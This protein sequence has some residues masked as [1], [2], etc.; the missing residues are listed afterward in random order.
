MA[1]I[2]LSPTPPES[3][4]RL[5]AE[6]PTARGGVLEGFAVLIV[7]LRIGEAVLGIFK[8]G[9]LE[10]SAAVFVPPRP[11]AP[12]RFAEGVVGTTQASYAGPW[13]R[14]QAWGPRRRKLVVVIDNAV[15]VEE[16]E[17]FFGGAIPPAGYGTKAEAPIDH[18]AD[19]HEAA[20][21][22]TSATI[23][24]SL[25]LLSTS[26]PLPVSASASASVSASVSPST[27]AGP[28]I[29]EPFAAH[30]VT[31]E[32]MIETL[33][34]GKKGQRC[35]ADFEAFAWDAPHRESSFG[36]RGDDAGEEAD[37]ASSAAELTDILSVENIPKPPRR[38]D[39]DDNF[40]RSMDWVRA[41]G[42]NSIEEMLNKG[43]EHSR[44]GF[45]GQF[46]ATPYSREQLV[47]GINGSNLTLLKLFPFL[48]V[49][50]P[51][52]P[53]DA[54]EK[55]D[56][57]AHKNLNRWLCTR[58]P[59]DPE[60]R[61]YALARENLPAHGIYNLG[62]GSPKALFLDEECMKPFG[63]L[64]G[65]FGSRR[66]LPS[67]SPMELGCC[68]FRSFVPPAVSA[69]GRQS[70][71]T[72]PPS[73]SSSSPSSVACV[74]PRA[75]ILA[76][77]IDGT[78]IK[79]KGD[80]AHA[81]TASDFV[82]AFEGAFSKVRDFHR[83]GFKIV[84]FTNQNGIHSGMTHGG[85]VLNRLDNVLAQLGVPAQLFMAPNVGNYRKP[86]A[87]MFLLFAA[88]C[89]GGVAVDF[90][91]SLFVGDMAGRPRDRSD[92]DLNFARISG[93]RFKT[94]EEF[95]ASADASFSAALSSL[96]KVRDVNY[97]KDITSLL[98]RLLPLYRARNARP[99]NGKRGDAS[100]FQ[101][102][103]ALTK[104]VGIISRLP[105]RV[106][107]EEK[108]AALRALPWI[109][110]KTVEKIVEIVTTGSLQRLV[111]LQRDVR[112]EIQMQLIKCPHIGPSTA[113]RLRRDHH[114][115]S[116]EDVKRRQ[117]ELL[118][119][120]A[121]V[122]SA[123]KHLPYL[124]DLKKRIPRAESERVL[125]AMTE[126][127]EDKCPGVRFH[128]LMGG[129]FRR[130]SP[131]TS[132]FDCVLSPENV[133]IFAVLG[134]LYREMRHRKWIAEDISDP[135]RIIDGER[136][137][138]DGDGEGGGRD[139]DEGGGDDCTDNEAPV[140]AAPVAGPKRPKRRGRWGSS[141]GG[142]GSASA[143]TDSIVPETSTSTL[144]MGIMRH[145]LTGGLARRIDI[146][147]VDWKHR[148][149]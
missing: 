75:K 69:P 148:P 103:E 13:L 94:P 73:S 48:E 29:E 9:A 67:P 90:C 82:E 121:I 78:L 136:V 131:D 133:G 58:P 17:E 124:G 120:G 149:G 143:Q 56:I 16:Y 27:S 64:N 66:N 99:M 97:N 122:L 5:F 119:K 34:L 1:A 57:T 30:Y 117:D 55:I 14:W 138:R 107:T 11:P 40:K 10:K 19:E 88:R 22:S 51:L 128:L 100:D 95:F 85:V 132:D 6:E 26:Q 140:A 126:I 47:C 146:R 21:A 8:A 108:A 116:I 105:F 130:G 20:P 142:K 112:L 49:V 31:K 147:A 89:N 23:L 28:E 102:R 115:M 92:S 72:L 109:G 52:V 12:R 3:A 43:D 76:L 84:L 62:E 87:G 38:E 91:D 113:R 134:P 86:R 33:A 61:H 81:Q 2:F 106:D 98:V 45:S 18:Y 25:P 54:I 46:L 60:D 110:K 96:G 36:R 127:I 63:N 123:V 39:V 35:V 24:A 79:N 77:D 41:N 139:D 32:W 125:A 145:E 50:I 44:R 104:A 129:S 53:S 101:R 70:A 71:A 80:G 137:A 114:I 59:L 37:P 42:A 111:T 144:Y 68:V 15:T 83:A 93:L 65:G 4:A 118:E 135:Q 141:K 74:E 7:R